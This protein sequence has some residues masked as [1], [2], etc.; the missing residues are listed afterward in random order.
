[1]RC[2]EIKKLVYETYSDELRDEMEK[3]ERSLN[4]DFGRNIASTVDKMLS[5]YDR[6]TAG[7]IEEEV[8][9][10][11]E[12]LQK[13]VGDRIEESFHKQAN[14]IADDCFREFSES[15]NRIFSKDKNIEEIK[16]EKPKIIDKF[17]SQI[18]RVCYNDDWAEPRINKFQGELEKKFEQQK[19]KIVN[20]SVKEFDRLLKKQM[21]NA[22]SNAFYDRQVFTTTFW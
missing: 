10:I 19:E 13:E 11:R 9:R 22:V 7:Y 21:E 18:L 3:S 14:M 1:M 16:A 2:Q 5:D 6:E 20:D 17:K 4:L 15:A 12:E 8:L